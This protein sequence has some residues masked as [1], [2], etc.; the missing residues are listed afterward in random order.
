MHRLEHRRKPSRRI[1]VP[2]WGS[3]H[4]AGYDRSNVRKDVSKQVARHHHVE[5]L[6]TPHEVH[7]CGIYEQRLRLHPGILRR[8]SLERLVPND[9]PVALRVRFRDRGDT[10]LPVPRE[11]QLECVSNH[12]FAPPTRE[13]ARLNAN[14][15]GKPAILEPTD[16]RVFPLRVLTNH[17]HVD[18][19]R[20]LA[21]QRR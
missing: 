17:Y 9:Q 19:T 14:L 7:A 1:D 20:R 8:H 10:P 16:I 4:A 15:I 5:R 11:R 13:D 21:L 18:V 2:A 3:A 6:W 12:A